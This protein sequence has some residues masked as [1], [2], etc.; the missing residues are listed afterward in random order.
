MSNLAVL[1]IALPFL[2]GIIVA[3]FHKKLIAARI[4]SIV[5]SVIH[6]GVTILIFLQVNAGGSIVLELG[7]WE[8]PYGIV[9]V[10]DPL[11]ALLALTTAIIGLAAVI[12][13]PK[14]LSELQ[15]EFYFYSF[16]FLLISGV[17]GAFLTGDLF[18]L[19]VF[20][21]VLLMAS[22]GL[23]I[24]GNG[25][26]QLRESLKYILI[27][28]FSSMLFVTTISFLYSVVGTV[29]MAQAAERVG[30]VEQQGILTTIAILFF[31]VFAT[32]AAVFPL[33]YWLPNSYTVPN[34]VVSALFG[35]LL[36]KV[37]IYSILRTFTLIFNHELTLTNT[38]FI[39]LAIF[40][41]IFGVIGALSTNNVKLIIAYNIIPA[42]GFMLMG[43]G[44]FTE[45][46][47]A[48][49]IYYLVHDMIIK[50]VLFMLIGAII[51]VAGTSDLNKMGGLIHHYPVL[52]WMFF[53]A[54][55]VLA[56]IPPFSGFIGKLLLLQGGL[57]QEEILVVL[58]ALISS[59]GILFSM[60]R[61]FIKGFWGEPDIME[62]PS[63]KPS[64]SLM[65]W[66]IGLLLTISII[67]G[68]GAEWFYPNIEAIA[69]YVMNPDLYIESVLKE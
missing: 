51:Y 57:A 33:Y 36:T 55:L 16:F 64:L 49:S 34:A 2:A 22:Y 15:E 4:F 11:S 19:F 48:G 69:E 59:L 47:I 68:V 27:N 26:A 56:G 25:K 18:N 44:I 29:N 7:N 42:V 14:S 58:A 12:Y 13:A 50:A 3:F 32:K 62:L 6:L 45:T 1:P 60:M 37:G 41:M 24:L 61:I 30:E 5:A 65:T 43:I 63:Q 52:G 67:L 53:L 20:F 23:I 28:L 46:A 9:L 10:A 54:T 39:Y 38:L 40:T 21:E 17:S 31:F 35:A 66:P 8:A